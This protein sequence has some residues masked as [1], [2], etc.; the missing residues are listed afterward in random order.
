MPYNPRPAFQPAHINAE[1]RAMREAGR[2]MLEIARA[3]G[4]PASTLYRWA[5]E[6]DWRGVDIAEA[7]WRGS[8]RGTGPGARACS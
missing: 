4:V 3:V 2:P 6:N 1:A 5:A 7:A 8:A